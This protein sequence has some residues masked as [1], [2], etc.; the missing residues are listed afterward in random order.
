MKR[1]ILWVFLISACLVLANSAAA[2]DQASFKIPYKF[3]AA[4]KKLPAGT[5]WIETKDDGQLLIRQEVK[6]IE[7]ILPVLQR[8]PQP[9][10]PI[11][12]PQVTLDAVGNFEPPSRPGWKRVRWTS[13]RST[14]RTC[15]ASRTRASSRCSS[16]CWPASR[17]T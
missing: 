15:S 7:I 2:S 12:E 4:G 6:G 5:Y 13:P 1:N 16:L 8:M 14:P 11:A 10:P 9:T 17:P 3:E